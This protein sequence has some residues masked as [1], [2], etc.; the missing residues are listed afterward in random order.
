MA[1]DYERLKKEGYTEEEIQLILQDPL[2]QVALSDAPMG[3][4]RQ[5]KAATIT[6]SQG[7]SMRTSN[8]MMGYNRRGLNLP[9]GE[10]VS[11]DELS[12]AMASFLMEDSENKTI[13]C[14]STGKV[15]DVSSLT[16]TVIE[17]LV[18]GPGVTLVG[19]SDKI[20]NQTTYTYGIR[21][22]E[23]QTRVFMAGNKG[24]EMP[25]GEY[26]TLDELQ[27]AISD[28]VYMVK[29]DPVIVPPI[30]PPVG[31]G[32][33]ETPPNP[34][35]DQGEEE[36]DPPVITPPGGSNPPMDQGDNEMDPPT[37]TPTGGDNEPITPEDPKDEFDEPS[38]DDNERHVVTGRRKWEKWQTIAIAVG[39][40][41]IMLVASLGLDNVL[42]QKQITEI[43][44][45]ASYSI[46]QMSEQQVFETAE[47]A[48]QRAV[49][50]L[51]TGDSVF[52]EEG[53]R[54]DHESDRA[55]D[56]HGIIGQ[57]LRQEGNYTLEYVSILDGENNIIDVEFQE[58]VNLG[59]I[60]NQTLEERGLTLSD[61]QVRVH[62]GGPVA[63]WID[64]ADILSE[65]SITPQLIESKFVVESTYEG[66]DQNFDGTLDVSTSNGTVELDVMN[67]DGTLV[68][69]GSTVI[70]SDGNTYTVDNI[71]VDHIETTTTYEEVVGQER[72]HSIDHLIE[73]AGYAA[74]AEALLIGGVA[75][76]G[77]AI[78]KKK[79][80]DE[81][82]KAE[83]EF[84]QTT[85]QGTFDETIQR[86]AAMPNK[87]L[88]DVDVNENTTGGP[89]R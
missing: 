89:R 11:A 10:Y 5:D 88:E 50:E 46:S 24:F 75:A 39:T 55:T 73:H 12:S 51:S 33:G 74:I 41:I 66:I 40:A 82:K 70:G 37:H 53:T 6:D 61:V 4:G 52:V 1:T 72:T 47:D 86:L 56:K 34:P 64:V 23:K 65:E 48:I 30:I 60:V 9:S 35:M 18:A 54:F 8:V 38:K 14:R 79:K 76:L 87:T 85:Y 3:P 77:M 42:A 20:T 32:G 45:K 16:S 58:G 19:K 83:E 84:A 28:Y 43:Q 68:S 27:G 2:S 22:D 67:P 57:G 44:E 81:E 15:V 7:H 25:N 71:S 31:P 59:D 62:I 17:A 29:D 78:N 26:V 13:V 69:G 80:E 21:G 49:S 63:G 36:K